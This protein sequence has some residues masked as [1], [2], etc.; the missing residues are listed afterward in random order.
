MAGQKQEIA[1]KIMHV[2]EIDMEALASFLQTGRYTQDC[3]E[4][5][6]ALNVALT[7]K[8]YSNM[9]TGTACG[10][11]IIDHLTLCVQ[12]LSID[13]LRLRQ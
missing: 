13:R 9:V 5:I 8:P 1:F 11:C 2:N 12:S 10:P 7:H 3:T 4:A 6:Q